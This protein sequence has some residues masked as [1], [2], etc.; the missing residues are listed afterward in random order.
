MTAIGPNMNVVALRSHDKSDGFIA[1]F[2][3]SVTEGAIYWVEAIR[4]SPTQ[5]ICP[6][7][8]CGITGLRLEG[9]LYLWCPNMFRPLSGGFNCEV[10]SEEQVPEMA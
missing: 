8:G 6:D 3:E 4:D 7:D 10:V 1:G 5:D 9:K 2:D